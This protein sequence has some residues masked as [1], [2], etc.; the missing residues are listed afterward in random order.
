[1]QPVAQGVSRSAAPISE[2]SEHFCLLSA[3]LPTLQAA[4]KL[5]PVLELLRRHTGLALQVVLHPEPELSDLPLKSYYRFALPEFVHSGE[6]VE[7]DVPFVS[8]LNL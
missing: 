5:A 1:V 3:L 4:Q 2:A 7:S 6:R 8:K